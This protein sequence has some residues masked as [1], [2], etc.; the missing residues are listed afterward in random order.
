VSPLSD[1]GRAKSGLIRE[2]KSSHTT[3]VQTKVGMVSIMIS[4]EST[5][6]ACVLIR[7]RPGRHFEVAK[8]IA[9]LDGV[10]S[11]FAV[12]GGADV[13]ARIEV[14]GM[15]AL[16]ALGTRIGNHSDVVTTETLV[17]AEE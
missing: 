14:K 8:E 7:V 9:S 3:K 2:L 11:A 5:V 10:K 6:K 15:R 17:A 1:F 12:M 16:T 13:V 4:T